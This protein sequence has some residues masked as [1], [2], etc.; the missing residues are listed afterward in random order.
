MDISNNSLDVI[1]YVNPDRLLSDLGPISFP[2]L[3]RK[4]TDDG[5][6]TS[7]WSEE[8][9]DN[10]FKKIRRKKNANN[11]NRISTSILH[12]SKG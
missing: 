2:V 7:I 9:L 1:I 11:I 12:N 4:S 8:V 10:T 3:Y 5:E 6:E